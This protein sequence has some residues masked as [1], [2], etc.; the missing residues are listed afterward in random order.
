MNLESVFQAFKPKHKVSGTNLLGK[1]D[2]S[3]VWY[4]VSVERIVSKNLRFIVSFISSY[5]IRYNFN[6]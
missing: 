1:L 3:S 4:Q 5:S 6:S 2:S